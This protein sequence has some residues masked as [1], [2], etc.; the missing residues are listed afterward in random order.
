MVKAQKSCLKVQ[1]NS[2]FLYFTNVV[3]LRISRKLE[4]IETNGWQILNLLEIFY[5]IKY[6]NKKI[7]RVDNANST[8]YVNLVSNIN[9]NS[10]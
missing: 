2:A 9:Q 4:E 5:K 7:E 1:K 6:L 8:N 10:I 3:C